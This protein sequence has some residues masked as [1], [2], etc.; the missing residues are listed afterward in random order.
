[1]AY[2]KRKRVIHLLMFL[3]IWIFLESRDVRS[4]STGEFQFRF[5]G[6]WEMALVSPVGIYFLQNFIM[7]H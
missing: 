5:P 2:S 4:N 1:M 6:V 3:L 7:A